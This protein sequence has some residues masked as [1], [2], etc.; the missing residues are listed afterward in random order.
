MLM[1][2][3]CLFLVLITCSSNLSHPFYS[4]VTIKCTHRYKI[5]I[6]VIYKTS[7]HMFYRFFFSFFFLLFFALCLLISIPGFSSGM[8]KWMQCQKNMRL[9]LLWDS[10]F[11]TELLHKLRFCHDEATIPDAHFSDCLRSVASQNAQVCPL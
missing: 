3:S 10:P 7:L 1:S 8:K 4:D 2:D 11:G 5:D 6:I 9:L